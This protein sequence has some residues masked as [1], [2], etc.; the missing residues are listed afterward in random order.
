[1]DTY[2]TRK[3]IKTLKELALIISKLKKQGKRAVHCHGV[4]DLMH[5]G[6][7]RHFEAA[8]REGDALVVTITKNIYVNKGPSRPVFDEWL[9][10]EQIAALECVDY[11]AINE[12]STAEK[13]IRLLKPN[14]YA[15]GSD[16]ED[17]KA[18]VTR[19]I[20][21]EEKAVRFCGGQIHF[22]REIQFSST[23]IINEQFDIYP[24][25]ARPFL[26]SFRSRYR[27]I[28]II[29]YL[30]SLKKL[31]VLVIGDAIVDEYCY[32]QPM[33]KSPKETIVS[34]RYIKQEAFAGG[35]LACANH[36]AGFC[37]TVDLVT[38]LGSKDSRESF[39]RSHLKP[40]VTS[41]F[42][43]RDD[44]STIIKRRFVDNAFLAKMFETSYLT[45]TPINKSLEDKIIKYLNSCAGR[46]DFVFVAD[47]GH[48]F[49]T[50]RIIDVICR[51]SKFLALNAQTNSSNIGFNLI[52]KYP[53]ADYVCIDEPE[54]RLAT[55]ARY[56]GLE[57]MVLYIAKK[58]KT[59]KMVSTRG[60]LGSMAY[61]RKSGFVSVPVLSQKVVDRTG[62]GDAY[63]SITAPCVVKDFPLEVIGFIGNTV[64]A[65][66]VT[67]VCNRSSIEPVTLYKFITTLLH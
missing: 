64:G 6:H 30:E 16:Y 15:K 66:A 27:D 23:G 8:K 11:V 19:G 20:E 38:A 10:A 26:E 58:L 55:H 42:F 40:N 67:I 17:R 41:K 13:T 4:F 48:G 7:I 44:A 29:N 3:K 22:T 25:D 1:M 63:F 35:I 52:T 51:K 65:L 53:C 46:Y 34:T 33:G 61:S 56:G 54:L 37:G 18:D 24:A 59:Q 47:Y 36:L 60:H 12:W 62:A 39:I 45:D 21:A 31:K 28:D 2:K 14:I 49:L 9:R 32:C 57:E 43:F 5:P 50:P